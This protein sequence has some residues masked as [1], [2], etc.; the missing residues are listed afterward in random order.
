MQHPDLVLQH[1]N[2]TLQHTSETD[3][4]FGTYT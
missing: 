2:E 4:I 1:L 3:E